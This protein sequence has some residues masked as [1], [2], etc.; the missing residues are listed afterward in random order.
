MSRRERQRDEI[1]SA[2]RRYEFAR[3]LVLCREHLAD[4]PDDAD[5][6]K[7]GEYAACKRPGPVSDSGT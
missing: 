5:V 4:F 6:Q 3:V 2:L 7:A 1:M